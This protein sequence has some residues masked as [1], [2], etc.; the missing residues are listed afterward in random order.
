MAIIAV[1]M[2]FT[3]FYVALS[4]SSFMGGVTT[5]ISGSNKDVGSAPGGYVMG[6]TLI[7]KLKDVPKEGGRLPTFLYAMV[8]SKSTGPMLAIDPDGHEQSKRM[9]GSISEMY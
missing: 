8:Q 7:V 1:A 6:G 3:G 9:V 4:F 2:I 5:Q